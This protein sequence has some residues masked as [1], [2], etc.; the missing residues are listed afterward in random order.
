MEDALRLIIAQS[1]DA[2]R[3]AMKT[4]MAIRAGSP[5]VQQR[6]NHV[7]EIALADPSAMFT[8]Q[9]RALIAEHISAS[10]VETRDNTLSLRLTCEERAQ[11][12]AAASAAGLSLSQYAR[13]RMF[14]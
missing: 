9:E 4:L 11:L 1:P 6:Y 14:A 10:D 13:K 12:E 5:A 2:A 7:V 8:A 3:E